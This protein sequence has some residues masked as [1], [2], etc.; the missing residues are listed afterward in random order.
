MRLAG[1]CICVAAAPFCAAAMDLPG[2][3]R[4]TVREPGLESLDATRARPLFSPSRRPPPPPAPIAAP[5]LPPAPV[6]VAAPP[7]DIQLVGVVF[8]GRTHTAIV[9]HPAD[10][11]PINVEVGDQ[12]DGWTVTEIRPR[13]IVLEHGPRTVTI[14]LPQPGH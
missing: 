13:E 5:I 1:L 9:E 2:S 11:R 4:Q 12:I 6:P 8:G 14:G 10:P 7:P 3:A